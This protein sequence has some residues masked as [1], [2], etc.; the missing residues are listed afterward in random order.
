MREDVLDSYGW[1][2]IMALDRDQNLGNSDT[3]G[4]LPIPMASLDY[5]LDLLHILSPQSP[6]LSTSDGTLKSRAAYLT[7]FTAL[8]E[9]GYTLRRLGGSTEE[10]KSANEE[11]ARDGRLSR[12]E[13]I[14]PEEYKP[15]RRKRWLGF[16]NWR[17]ILRRSLTLFGR[18]TRR[19][20]D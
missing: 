10:E 17:S 13:D 8:I 16:G 20:L 12:Y 5:C 18:P 3:Y 14:T 6:F 7:A 15:S 2:K 4:R 11:A 1:D 19:T 9:R